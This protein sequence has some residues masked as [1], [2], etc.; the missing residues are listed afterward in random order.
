MHRQLRVIAVLGLGLAACG[1]NADERPDGGPHPDAPPID[2]E[3]PGEVPR[4]VPTACRYEVPPLFGSEGTDYACGDLV[5]WENRTTQTRAIKVHYI[6]VKGPST[7]NATIYL[8]GGPGGDGENILAY[9]GFLGA[10]F[11]DAVRGDGDFL[12]IGQRGTAKSLPFLECGDTECSE[13]AGTYDLASYNTAENADDVDDLRAVLGYEKLDL[14]GISYGSRLGLEVL[15]R[16]GDNVRA[17]LIEGLVPSSVAWPAAVPASFYS[18]LTGLNASCA[19]GA[20]GTAFGNLVTKF[21]Q[22]VASLDN[23]PVTVLVEGTPFELDGATYAYILFRSFY[24]KSTFTWL[25]M[26]ISDLAARRVDRVQN[27]LGNMLANLGGSSGISRGLYNSVVCGEIFNPPDP[28]AFDELNAGVP[29]DIVDLFGYNWFGLMSECEAWPVGNLQ[30]Q[31]AQ[32][33]TSDVRTLVSSG[34]LDPITPPGFGDIAA[35]TLSNSVVVLHAN[36]GH[37][38]TLQSACGVANLAAFI[39]NPTAA[40]DTSCAATISTTYQL[41]A[42]LVAP[43]MS[44]ARVR[45]E[46]AMAPVPPH[47][48]VLARA[49]I[50]ATLAIVRARAAR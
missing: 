7:G 6:Q 9:A 20:C 25:P 36:S 11:L 23:A 31:L 49:R 3:P 24:S 26:V 1:D 13:F 10:P 34:R 45:A 8:D 37:G 39:A 5:V 41:P 18:A 30:A 47:V 48:G 27:F 35:S 33:V 14:Y 2:A 40:N 12:V 42:Q 22:G 15:R 46:L 21:S 50:A 4:A 19:A 38:A 43:T 29:A 32:P 17:A 28:N 44:W 16:H